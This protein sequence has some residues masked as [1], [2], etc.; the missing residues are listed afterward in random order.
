MSELH[1]S[2]GLRLNSRAGGAPPARSPISVF[3]QIP[4]CWCCS[5]RPCNPTDFRAAECHRL[6]RIPLHGDTMM[7][8]ALSSTINAGVLF[9]MLGCA[10]LSHYEG[11]T[12]PIAF[13]NGSV[14][15]SGI[16]VEPDGNGPFPAVVFVHGSGPSTIHR[17]A[18]KAHANAFT[19]RGFAVLVYDQRGSCH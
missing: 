2:P 17:P 11:R 6:T 12:E 8:R 13:S 3:K 16:L 1:R 10:S 5:N 4:R 7:N 9:C 14:R 19:S 15:L 18:C